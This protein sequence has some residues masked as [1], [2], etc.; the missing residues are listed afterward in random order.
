MYVCVCV[1]VCV[2]VCVCVCV[3][4]CVSVCVYITV[5]PES[6]SAV[7]I[8]RGTCARLR[9]VT[10]VCNQRRAPPPGHLHGISIAMAAL[11]CRSCRNAVRRARRRRR[12]CSDALQ[13]V[14]PSLQ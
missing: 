2:S 7:G 14:A 10:R 9:A 5:V 3:C 8:W 1:C 11:R 13:A 12:P 6:G 4:V